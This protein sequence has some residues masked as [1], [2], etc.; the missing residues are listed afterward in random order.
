MMDQENGAVRGAGNAS[1]RRRRL[2]HLRVAVL[3]EA[4]G[5]GEW[6]NH[7]HADLV[8]LDLLDQRDLVGVDDAEAVLRDCRHGDRAVLA[9]VHEEPTSD[10]GLVD[11][12][13]QQDRG[14]AAVQLV[15]RVLQVEHCCVGTGE[16]VVS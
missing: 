9:R 15:E 2:D 16:H 6:V 13:L 12:V 5:L 3:F 14:E 4:V 1:P 11:V 7:E 8:H 10:I